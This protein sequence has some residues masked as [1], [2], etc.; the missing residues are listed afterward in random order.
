MLEIP[1]SLPGHSFARQLEA[2]AVWACLDPALLLAKAKEIDDAFFGHENTVGALL[3][4]CPTEPWRWPAYE[5]LIDASLTAQNDDEDEVPA[6]DD[7]REFN[8]DALRDMVEHIADKLRTNHMALFR[9]GQIDE[10]Q[11]LRPFWQ[12]HGACFGDGVEK[13]TYLA[14]NSFW[15]THCVPWNCSR[16]V[17]RCR[18]YSLSRLEM[19]RYVEAGCGLGDEAAKEQLRIFEQGE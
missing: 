8:A 18:V 3:T 19:A 7:V 5:A 14:T 6:A 4:A 15:K 13:R 1:K 12:V 9:K 10:I 2:V 16:F 11:R 17:C